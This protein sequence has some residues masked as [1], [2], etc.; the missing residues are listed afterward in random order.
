M[1]YSRAH[2]WWRAEPRHGETNWGWEVGLH[3]TSASGAGKRWVGGWTPRELLWSQQTGML[4]PEKENVGEK[5]A[6]K[7]VMNLVQPYWFDTFVGHPLEMAWGQWAIWV[8]S[9]RETS[10]QESDS[11]GHP[12]VVTI[13]FGGVTEIPWDVLWG[14][15]GSGAVIL[16]WAKQW[17]TRGQETQQDEGGEHFQESS[18]SWWYML[19]VKAGTLFF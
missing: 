13:D 4:F 15:G 9:S 6:F 16:G 14:L 18:R 7:M 2:G 11:M 19:Q 5:P 8:Q 12:C 10:G 1:S 17:A 3:Q